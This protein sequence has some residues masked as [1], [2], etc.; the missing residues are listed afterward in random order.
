MHANN[1]IELKNGSNTK[2]RQRESNHDKKM[3]H[4]TI[5]GKEAA[6][7]TM[8]TEKRYAMPAFFVSLLIRKRGE[9]YGRSQCNPS[10]EASVVG[11]AQKYCEQVEKCRHAPHSVEGML[12]SNP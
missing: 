10:K 6:A 12:P 4:N 2:H 11:A 8:R 1:A 9:L 3:T 7:T 5:E